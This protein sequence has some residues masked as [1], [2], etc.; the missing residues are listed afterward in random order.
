MKLLLMFL[1]ET[2]THGEMPLHE[3]LVQNLTHW[4][5]SGATAHRG[6]MGFGQGPHVHR[7]RLFGVSDDRPI[8]IL[9][10]DT[11]E[12]LRATIPGLRELAPKIPMLLLDAEVV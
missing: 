3:A 5:V 11:E 1:S 7:N 10:A 12:R 6:V 9:A 2:D 8:T 4:G